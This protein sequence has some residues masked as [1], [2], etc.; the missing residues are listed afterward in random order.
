MA[1]RGRES[2]ALRESEAKFSGILGIAADAIISVDQ[3]QHIV[4]FNQG[5]ETDLRLSGQGDH[6]AALDAAASGALSRRAHQAHRRFRA[7]PEGA[8]RMGE[9]REIFGLRANG[10]E[11]PAEASISKLVPATEFCSRSC[12]ATSRIAN[13][14]R[15]TSGSSPPPRPS[16]GHA[17]H[18]HRGPDRR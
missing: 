2:T 3:E 16:G 6:R 10:T 12:C 13:E 11:F 14:R 5:A 18:R 4:H 17:R 15:K 8:R 1:E 7:A 9:R